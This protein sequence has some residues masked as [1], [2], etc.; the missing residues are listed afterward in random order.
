MHFWFMC[1]SASSWLIS[2]WFRYYDSLRWAWWIPHRDGDNKCWG[3]RPKWL[4]FKGPVHRTEND[5]KPN[6]TR[7]FRTVPAVAIAYFQTMQPD[8]FGPVAH[9]I[10]LENVH[11]LSLFW[12]ET[13][14][15]WMRCGQNDMLWQ[16]PTCSTSCYD[17]RWLRQ[18]STVV[19]SKVRNQISLE[20]C[21]SWTCI[22][23]L[24]LRAKVQVKGLSIK[25]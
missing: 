14:Q 12:R 16:N 20:E 3:T 19:V 17:F 7:P 23:L 18:S 22:V 10:P 2:I 21:K 6:W 8:W 24:G 4:V 13:A 25:D 9:V 11:I 15:K 1:F 5:Q